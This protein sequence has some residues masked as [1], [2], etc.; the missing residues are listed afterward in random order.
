MKLHA[1]KS[2]AIVLPPNDLTQREKDRY[3]FGGDKYS[4]RGPDYPGDIIRKEDGNFA[5]PKEDTTE[6]S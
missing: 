3:R 5:F 4:I 1:I 6:E 2:K